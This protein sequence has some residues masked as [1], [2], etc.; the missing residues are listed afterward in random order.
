M[1]VAVGGSLSVSLGFLADLLDFSMGMTE[2]EEI[3]FYG[4]DEG[5]A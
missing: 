1:C 2:T 5:R 4:D 3:G